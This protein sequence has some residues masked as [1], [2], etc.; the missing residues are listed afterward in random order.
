MTLQRHL[1]RY[2]EYIEDIRPKRPHQSAGVEL[3]KELTIRSSRDKEE[4][5]K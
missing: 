1:W 4:F 5:A 2:I 3:P